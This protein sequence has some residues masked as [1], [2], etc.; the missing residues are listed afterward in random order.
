MSWDMY[1]ICTEICTE[2]C[3]EICIGHII[4]IYICTLYHYIWW[5]ASMWEIEVVMGTSSKLGDFPDPSQSHP[6]WWLP[7]GLVDQKT[8]WPSKKKGDFIFI[9]W[10]YGYMYICIYVYMYILYIYTYMYVIYIYTYIYN[11]HILTF[12]IMPYDGYEH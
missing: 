1:G 3:I 5:W 12:F 6:L 8:P 7:P 9:S 4:C 2:I 11:I 10:G